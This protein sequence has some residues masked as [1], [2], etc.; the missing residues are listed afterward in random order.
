MKLRSDFE[1]ARANLMNRHPAPSLDVCFSELIQEEQR[2]LTQTT[3]EQ[4]ETTSTQMAFLAHGKSKG[5]DMNKVQCFSCKNYGHIAANCTQKFCNY[6]KKH[7]HIIKDCLIR[8]QN[9]HNTTFQATTSNSPT[10]QFPIGPP[11][12]SIVHQ[13]AQSTI[14]TPEMVQQMIILAFSVLKLQGNGN[15]LSKSWLVDSTASNHMTNSAHL[16]QNVRPYHGSENIQVA[17]GNYVPIT[18]VS[19][20]TPVFNNA[21][22]SPGLS[23]NLLSVGQ[24]VDNNCT[25]NFSRHGCC[26]QDQ[27]SRTMIAKGL[28]SNVY[29]L[30]IFP[31]LVLCLKPIL[32]FLVPMRC[33]IN[34]WATPIL[35]YCLT[36]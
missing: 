4:E 32:L 31:F 34:V 19:D 1:N 25:I 12:M 2:L 23:D 30:C 9:R 8:P 11:T 5:K 16:L 29:F 36:Y 33:G 10:S 6:C 35:L 20:I 21:F 13:H 17:N 22:I 28:K 27:D 26:V 14:L 7:G 24:L 15:S 3:L 18:S